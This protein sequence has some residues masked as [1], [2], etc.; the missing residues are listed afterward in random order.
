VAEQVGKGYVTISANTAK[1]QTDLSVLG[2]ELG[3]KFG[4]LGQLL[5][6]KLGAGLKKNLGGAEGSVSGLSG[7]LAETGGGGGFG[8]L[9]AGAVAATAGVGVALYKMGSDF[10]QTNRNIARQTGQTGKNLTDLQNDFKKVGQDSASSF[11]DIELALVG[12]QRFTGPSSQLLVPLTKQLTTL[13]RISG[14]DV[15]SNV[16]ASVRAME[17][18]NIP[19]KDAG[20]A[21]DQL[22]TGSQRSGVSFADLSGQVTKFAPQLTTMGYNFQRSVGV[23]SAFGKTGVNTSRIMAAMQIGASNLAAAQTKSGTAV[24]KAADEVFKYQDALGKAKPGSAAYK[25]AVDNL[26]TA[27]TKLSLAQAVAAKASKTTIPEA[28]A[29][30]IKSI[31]DAKTNTDALN[32]G[33]G[34]FGK[35]GALQMVQAIRSGKFNF[36]EMNKSIEHSGNSITTTA[37][38]TETIGAAFH[39][40]GNQAAVAFQP[41]SQRVFN[42]ISRG[43]INLA[44]DLAPVVNWIGKELPGAIRNVTG[45]VSE[46]GKQW[47]QN[48]RDISHWIRVVY[49]D[50]TP[51]R[52]LIGQTFTVAARLIED[53]WHVISPIFKALGDALA[54]VSY[55]LSGKWGEAWSAAKRFVFDFLDAIKN[56]PKLIFDLLTSPFTSLSPKIQ[57]AMDDVWAFL[58]SVPG[59]IGSAL[60]LVASSVWDAF[61]GAFKWATG[62]A[63]T[64]LNDIWAWLKALPGNIFNWLLGLG[65]SIWNAFVGGFRWALGAAES[66][67]STIWGWLKNLPG[68]IVGW[69]GDLGTQ[70]WTF[71]QHAFSRMLDGARNGITNLWQWALHLGENVVGWFGDVGTQL[72]DYGVHIMSRMADGVAGAGAN[73]VKSAFSHALSFLGGLVP[74]SPAKEGPLAGSGDPLYWGPAIIKRMAAGLDSSKG[75]LTNAFANVLTPSSTGPAA[76]ALLGLPGAP[77]AVNFGGSS[78][79]SV[80]IQ[81]ATFNDP[82]DVE[83]FLRQAAWVVQTRRI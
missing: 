56:V 15:K 32:I 29:S 80:V 52:H 65:G 75:I 7:L 36:D 54:F 70:I 31:K 73:L 34:V 53:A 50:I 61:V 63:Q 45:W 8:L 48:F 76:S 38:K 49:E 18:W 41:L 22:F 57:H 68:N 19:A 21:F 46:F 5:G 42:A 11:G 10:A 69:I 60:A 44:H 2:S 58:K 74:H 9:A 30:T 33:I 28:M 78:G 39:R 4:V 37:K 1:L 24:T 59:R 27:H 81:N 23:L 55:L 77:A 35:R 12:L 47:A 40:L 62:A 43:L 14:T 16:E 82:M 66:G 83:T 25:T 26:A 71:V 17:R 13:S 20:K 79:P 64:G 67:I 51:A 3:A 72:F 6:G